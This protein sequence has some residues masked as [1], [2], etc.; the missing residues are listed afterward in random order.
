M[1]TRKPPSRAGVGASVCVLPALPQLPLR[2]LDY[3][4]KAMP[5]PPGQSWQQRM[6]M[7]LVIAPD[8][9]ALEVNHPYQVGQTVYYY[10]H[11]EREAPMPVQEFIVYEDEQLLVADK[12]HFLPVTPSGQFLQQTLLVR[13]KNKTG[14]EDLAPLHR[15]DRDTAGL[16][17][18]SKKVESRGAYVALFRQRQIHKVY[19]AIAPEISA[20]PKLPVMQNEPFEWACHLENS[21]HSFM[22]MQENPH[23]PPNSFTRITLLEQL[24]HLCRY[25]LEPKSGKRHQLRA[26]MNALGAPIY[27]D[28]IYPTLTPEKAAAELDFASPLMLLAKQLQFTDPISKQEHLFFSKLSLPSLAQLVSEKR[29]LATR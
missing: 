4:N 11:I 25:R 28:N 20:K 12:P 24:G 9:Q 6:Q 14:L 10:R 1:T 7:G 18:F 17:L 19:E 21:P 22:Q 8:S 26:H 5:L 29:E 27:G 16:V 23:A 3:L 15:I 2:L 13:L